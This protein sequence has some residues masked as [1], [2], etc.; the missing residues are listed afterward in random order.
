MQGRGEGPTNEWPEIWDDGRC[1]ASDSRLEMVIPLYQSVGNKAQKLL[2][3]A[4]E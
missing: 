4:K 3:I 2:I 1:L